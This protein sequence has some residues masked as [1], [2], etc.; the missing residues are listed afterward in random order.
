[1]N[2]GSISPSDMSGAGSPHSPPPPLPSGCHQTSSLHAS[3]HNQQLQQHCGMLDGN[4]GGGA[5]H[6]NV[7]G[8]VPPGAHAMGGN[9]DDD[10]DNDGVDE[11]HSKEGLAQFW[12]FR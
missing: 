5:L 8:G 3:L 1:M 2:A 4:H 12:R 9:N 11:R 6:G 7:A 10:D